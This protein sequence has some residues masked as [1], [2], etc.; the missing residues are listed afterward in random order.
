MISFCIQHHPA[1]AHLLDGLLELVG[2]ADVVTDPDPEHPSPSPLRT[3]RE[4]LRSTPEG[5][6]HRVVIQDD[7]LPCRSFR[8]LAELA[9]AERPDKIIAFFVPGVPGGGSRRVFKAEM[10]GERWAQ[11]A[12]I[13]FLPLVATSWPADLIAPFVKFTEGPRYI[14]RRGDD[15]VANSFVK[16]NRLEVWATVPSLV[17]HPDIVASLI[18]KKASAGA[19]R[20]RVAALFIDRI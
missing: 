19:N 10:E 13:G 12:G 17:E 14:N 4:C 6:T 16:R 2:D 8:E 5:A 3:Y 9:I 20:S 7:A 15:A 11:I 18:G 1:R